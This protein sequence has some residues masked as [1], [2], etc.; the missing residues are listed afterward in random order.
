MIAGITWPV[1]IVTALVDSINPCAI[2]VL[3]LLISTL[4]TL[5]K[6]RFKMLTVGCVDQT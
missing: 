6:N 2:G 5:A 4:L 1:V 3:V